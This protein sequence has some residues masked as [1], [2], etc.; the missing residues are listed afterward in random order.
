MKVIDN[1]IN[2]V[3]LVDRAPQEVQE[4]S[5]SFRV[6]LDKLVTQITTQVQNEETQALKERAH[7]TKDLREQRTQLEQQL[8]SMKSVLNQMTGESVKKI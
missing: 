2:Q 8:N 6:K 7:L 1:L 3:K 4:E 5:D